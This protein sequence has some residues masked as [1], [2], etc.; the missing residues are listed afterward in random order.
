LGRSGEALVLARAALAANVEGGISDDSY[1]M[2]I[3]RKFYA[4]ALVADWP[5]PGS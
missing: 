1:V 3:S 5:I 2:A 4:T